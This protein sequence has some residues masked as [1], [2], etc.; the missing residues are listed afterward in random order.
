MKFILSALVGK[1]LVFSALWKIELWAVWDFLRWDPVSL[2]ECVWIVYFL[3]L[4]GEFLSFF[5]PLV[6]FFNG[7][8]ETR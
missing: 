7:R 1:S 2:R 3:V 5:L 4:E 8:E 6:D